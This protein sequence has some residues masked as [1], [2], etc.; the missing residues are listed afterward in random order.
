[1]T[2]KAVTIPAGTGFTNGNDE[3][4]DDL[5]PSFLVTTTQAVVLPASGKCVLAPARLVENPTAPNP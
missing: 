3:N 4:G 5:K 2:G 1:M